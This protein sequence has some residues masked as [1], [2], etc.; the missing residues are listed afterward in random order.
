MPS[1]NSKDKA[2]KQNEIR[3]ANKAKRKHSSKHQKT[4]EIESAKLSR[5]VKGMFSPQT[6]TLLASMMMEEGRVITGRS[7]VK[8]MFDN[9]LSV[10]VLDEENP[11]IHG[12]T[13]HVTKDGFKDE[14]GDPPGYQFYAVT[15]ETGNGYGVQFR[16]DKKGRMLIS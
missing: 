2:Q 11:L 14:D 3:R 5:F 6:K 9:K 13:F 7:F 12:K 15:V 1:A 16:W 4:K 10:T 8:L